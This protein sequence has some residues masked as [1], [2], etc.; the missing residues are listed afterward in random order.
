MKNSQSGFT[1]IELL[2][3]TAILMILTGLSLVAFKTNKALAEY[4]RG[5]ATLRSAKTALNAGLLELP[6]VFSLEITDS[7]YDGSGLSGELASAFPGFRPPPN[8]GLAAEVATC[9]QN[10]SALDRASLVSIKMC[11]IG[12]SIH[13]QRFCGGTEVTMER[14]AITDPCPT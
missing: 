14:V 9:D 7:G 11:R 1:L 13:W 2:V 3:T 12:Q 6:E 10:S 4:T 8:I 5:E